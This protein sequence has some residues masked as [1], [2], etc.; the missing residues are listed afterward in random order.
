M[1][2]HAKVPKI[3]SLPLNEILQAHHHAQF[4]LHGGDVGGQLGQVA[5]RLRTEEA[6]RQASLKYEVL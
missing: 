6:I 1:H 4:I 5:H 3:E 2:R